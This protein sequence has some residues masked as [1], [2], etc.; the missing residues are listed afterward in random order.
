MQYMTDER[1]AL[2]S[3]YHAPTGLMHAPSQIETLMS[4]DRVKALV[5]RRG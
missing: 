2:R 3:P 5:S 4:M 1:L